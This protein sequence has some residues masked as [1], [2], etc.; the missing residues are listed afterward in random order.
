MSQARVKELWIYPVKSFA[1]FQVSEMQVG[2]EGPKG[3]RRWMVVDDAGKFV[4]HRALPLM[5]QIMASYEGD[6]LRLTLSDVSLFPAALATSIAV[7]QEPQRFEERESRVWSDTILGQRILDKDISL[8]LSQALGHSL[9]LVKLNPKQPRIRK[10]SVHPDNFSVSLADGLPFLIVNEASV[11][12][13]S[14]LLSHPVPISAFRANI[15][16]QGMAPYEED[17]WGEFHFESQVNLSPHWTCV[18]CP[19]IDVVPDSGQTRKDV[20]KALLKWR[21][22]QEIQGFGRRSLVETAGVLK[23]GD[24]LRDTG[25]F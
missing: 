5:C 14:K 20:L 22:G 3:D 24:T 9:H 21:H 17:S 25:I 23:V 16:L 12:E 4:T 6:L 1:G 7:P 19:M 15:V 10:S 13:L 18:R 2:A 8:W 11:L